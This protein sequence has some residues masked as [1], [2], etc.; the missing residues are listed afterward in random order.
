[1]R[2]LERNHAGA[3]QDRGSV[4]EAKLRHN[5][6]ETDQG[7]GSAREAKPMEVANLEA[8]AGLGSLRLC[9]GTEGIAPDGVRTSC[10][11]GPWALG[12]I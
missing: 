6:A 11:A 2:P 5:R 12:Q 8:K 3:D 4:R 7:R 9:V 10:E 1:M